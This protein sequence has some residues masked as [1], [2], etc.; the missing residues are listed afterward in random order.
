MA[1]DPRTDQELLAAAGDRGAFG[2]LYRRNEQLIMRFIGARVRD[3]HLTADLTAETFAA[4]LE[5]V[6]RFDPMRGS[7]SGWLVGI[8]RNVLLASWRQGRVE[9]GAR[10]RLKMRPIFIEDEHLQTIARLCAEEALMSLD[11]PE[12]DAIARRILDDV[13]YAD[14]AT[15]LECSEQVVRQRVSRGLSRLRR[16]NEEQQ[17]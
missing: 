9:S 5:S 7:A 8:A 11:Q 13:S 1:S 2:E 4:A 17:P 3:P 15:E 12:R 10:Q 6:E 14:L 16:L